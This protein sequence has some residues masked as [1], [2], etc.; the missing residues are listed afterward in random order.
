MKKLISV[1]LLI[2]VLA[3]SLFGCN[4]KP[5]CFSGEWV[6]SS[7][8]EV[9]LVPNLSQGEIDNLKEGYNVQTEEEIVIKALEKFETEDTFATFYLKFTKNYTYTYDPL[10]ERE[11]TWKFYKLTENTGFI[12]FFAELDVSAGNPDPLVCPDLTYNSETDTMT[13]TM[14]YS[15][16]MVT[17]TLVK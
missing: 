12:S 6:F 5:K 15:S 9:E 2:T 3:V 16:F 4:S 11:A 7:I 17:L 13:I 14:N 1:F 8:V 10:M